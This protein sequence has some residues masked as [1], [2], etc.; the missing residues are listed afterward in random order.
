MGGGGSILFQKY[1]I[2]CD[3]KIFTLDLAPASQIVSHRCRLTKNNKPFSDK[4]VLYFKHI[5]YLYTSDILFMLHC[6]GI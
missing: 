3:N 2:L 4:V 5:I 1:P 6:L